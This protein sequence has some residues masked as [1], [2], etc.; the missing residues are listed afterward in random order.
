MVTN[1]AEKALARR[2]V[3]ASKG[4]LNY[5]QAL[6]RIAER[7]EWLR[8]KPFIE[9]SSE[10]QAA[11]LEALDAVSSGRD[12]VV[13]G[14][15]ASGK[16]VVAKALLEISGLQHRHF[17]DISAVLSAHDGIFE[18]DSHTE[19]RGFEAL[20]SWSAEDLPSELAVLHYVHRPIQDWLTERLAQVPRRAFTLYGISLRDAVARIESW[21]I[22]LRN[23]VFLK[24]E[25]SWH[26]D[27]RNGRH[28]TWTRTVFS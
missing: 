9:L 26:S 27:G 15:A 8:P 7:K 23:P 19:V 3:A 14:S 16:T 24:T 25:W 18:R 17:L 4:R 5:T 1:H 13:F 2:I 10:N 22:E 20:E 21:E 28:K 12:L 6:T 11:L